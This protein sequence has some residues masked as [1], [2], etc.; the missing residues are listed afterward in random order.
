MFTDT[1]KHTNS[2]LKKQIVSYIFLQMFS[3]AF[4]CV[5]NSVINDAGTFVS[6][7]VD[8]RRKTIL[9]IFMEHGGKNFSR[10][11]MWNIFEHLNAVVS[12]IILRTVKQWFHEWRLFVGLDARLDKGWTRVGLT[13]TSGRHSWK[14]SLTW[15]NL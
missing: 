10:S 1:H 8:H 5:I 15:A 4:F 3:K 12:R 14:I 9:G 13:D 7:I 6:Y 11:V 2:L